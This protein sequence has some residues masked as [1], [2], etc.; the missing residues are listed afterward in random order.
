MTYD[1][2]RAE[3]NTGIIAA[4]LPCLKPLFRRILEKSSWA[5]GSSRSNNKSKNNNRHSLHTFGPRQTHGS[6]YNNSVIASHNIKKAQPSGTGDNLSEENILPFQ[7]NNAITK[8][9]VVIVDSSGSKGDVETM[10]WSKKLDIAPE[11]MV[12]DRV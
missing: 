11:R 6:V 7:N 3:C 10:P 4:C 5:Y 12:E 9:T 2:F 8:T 1:L